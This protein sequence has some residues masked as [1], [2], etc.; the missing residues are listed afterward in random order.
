MNMEKVYTQPFIIEIDPIKSTMEYSNT[1]VSKKENDA[2][3]CIVIKC[4][5]CMGY[6]CTASNVFTCKYK[7]VDEMETL[8]NAWKP[9]TKGDKAR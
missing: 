4:I 9:P 8:E 3:R 5:W 7:T 6:K 1:I 2:S